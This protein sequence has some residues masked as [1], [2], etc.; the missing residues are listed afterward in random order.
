MFFN[1]QK[2]QVLVSSTKRLVLLD[3]ADPRN[4]VLRAQISV[5]KFSVI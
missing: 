5:K 4:L 2:T 1:S 3:V